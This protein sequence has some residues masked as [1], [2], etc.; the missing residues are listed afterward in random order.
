MVA[1]YALD[2]LCCDLFFVA[3]TCMNSAWSDPQH[4]RM[5]SLSSTHCTHPITTIGCVVC[6]EAREERIGPGRGW[7]KPCGGWI[8]R[9]RSSS[10]FFVFFGPG[11]VHFQIAVNVDAKYS[12]FTKF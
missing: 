7:E 8:E 2:G 1:G 5:L 11:S 12:E 6:V 3:R 9:D 4:V 10:C